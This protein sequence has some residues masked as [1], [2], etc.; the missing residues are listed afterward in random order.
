VG[1]DSS[2]LVSK[3]HVTRAL[4]YKSMSKRMKEMVTKVDK[5]KVYPFHEA[6]ALVKET[7][8]VKFDASVE[9]HALLP[10]V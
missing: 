4:P 6:V 9:L 3:Y 8:N 7:S 5:T 1:A 10:K 2:K